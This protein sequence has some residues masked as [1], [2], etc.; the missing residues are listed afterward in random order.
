[1][2]TAARSCSS[3][4]TCPSPFPPRPLARNP[5]RARVRMASRKPSG[6]NL[7]GAEMRKLIVVGVVALG[8]LGLVAGALARSADTYSFK[9]TLTRG[10][11]V[12]KPKGAPATAGGTFVAH[13]VEAG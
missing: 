11:E 8:A 12:P 2:P 9:A 10:A 4:Q 3:A 13:S 1:M 7:R 6:M 5:V